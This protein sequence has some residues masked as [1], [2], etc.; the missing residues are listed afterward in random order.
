MK[1]LVWNPY[2][3]QDLGISLGVRV[4]ILPVWILSV[5]SLD[6]VWLDP[7]CMRPVC[8]KPVGKGLLLDIFMLDARG[9]GAGGREEGAGRNEG[10]GKAFCIRGSRE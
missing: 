2:M 7:V 5:W 1:D 6:P 3:C 4:W 9:L 8:L 10:I